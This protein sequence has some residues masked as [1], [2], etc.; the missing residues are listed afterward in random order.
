[1]GFFDEPI[2]LFDDLHSILF[3]TSGNID[4]V[5]ETEKYFER[6]KLKKSVLA[7]D[8]LG[9]SQYENHQQ[10][11]LPYLFKILYDNTINSLAMLESYFFEDLFSA[12]M[13][14]QR[15]IDTGDGG[16]LIFDNPLQAILFAVYFERSLNALHAAREFS[17]VRN[18]FKGAIKVRYT[19]TWD[20]L[21]YVKDLNNY[22]GAAII[23]A[24]R[25][26]SRDKLDRC[27]CD[28][29]T[30]NWFLRYLQNFESL[31]NCSYAEIAK[32][33]NIEKAHAPFATST[34]SLCFPEAA[35][36]TKGI[37]FASIS[38]IGELTIKKT[39]V[40]VHSIYLQCRFPFKVTEGDSGFV[41]ALG[42]LNT[43]G[44][45]DSTSFA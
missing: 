29:N 13:E 7:I 10:I 2:P 25:I 31:S 14:R 44:I 38:K 43:D 45:Q 16:F 34:R 42:N 18:V 23:N 32:R 21:V 1:M 28:E 12:I 15:F 17:N 8:I 6:V 41:V 22:Y 11:V 37:S 40:S 24:A 9:Y 3:P 33:V 39:K 27:L 19:I 35:D 36:F 20:N 26:I 30:Y 4:A 5:K